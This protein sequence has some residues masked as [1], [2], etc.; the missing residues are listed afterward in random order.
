VE[1]LPGGTGLIE[2]LEVSE[3]DPPYVGFAVRLLDPVSRR[4]MMLYAN[5]TRTT[6]ARLEGEIEGRR[7]TWRSVTPGRTRESRT[8]SEP[9]DA[10]RWRRTQYVSEDAGAHWQVL[11][12]DEL[13]RDG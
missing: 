5:S 9:I 6:I 4:W 2:R 13:E 7:S 12:T 11:F 8:V 3:E 10:D 1:P